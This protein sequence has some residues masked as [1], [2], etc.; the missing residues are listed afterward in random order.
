LIE[1]LGKL[2]KFSDKKIKNGASLLEHD[3]LVTIQKRYIEDA[4]KTLI[5]EIFD[6]Q[7]IPRATKTVKHNKPS[8]VDNDLDQEPLILSVRALPV[9]QSKSVATKTKRVG[10]RKQAAVHPMR[11]SKK[12]K[13]RKG[14]HHRKPPP[15]SAVAQLPSKNTKDMTEAK[16]ENSSDRKRKSNLDTFED[17]SFSS[18]EYS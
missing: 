3:E 16:R 5:H 2:V 6:K 4:L 14:V 18:L 9:D 7:D 12:F 13:G 11:P 10:D 17:L 15:V 8:R 1:K